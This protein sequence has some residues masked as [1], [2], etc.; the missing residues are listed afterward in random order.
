MIQKR[1]ACQ[2]VLELFDCLP[3]YLRE[4]ERSKTRS[5]NIYFEIVLKKI[6]KLNFF[7]LMFL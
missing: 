2:L 5:I 4:R 7:D 1:T 3:K 6:S